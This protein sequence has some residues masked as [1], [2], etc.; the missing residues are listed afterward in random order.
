MSW[1]DAIFGWLTPIGAGRCPEARLLASDLELK[2]AIATV[3][4]SDPM[5]KD[6]EAGFASPTASEQIAAAVQLRKRLLESETVEQ[7]RRTVDRNQ[8]RFRI[9]A[10]PAAWE[11][12]QAT[13]PK[14]DSGSTATELRSEAGSLLDRLEL[15]YALGQQKDRTIQRIRRFGMIILVILLAALTGVGWAQDW[16][17]E[18][19]SLFNYLT[20][21]SAA[22]IGSL[23]SIMQ[24]TQGVAEA[25]PLEEDPVRQI[26]ALRHG[27]GGILVA[28][29]LGPM[30]GLT[31]FAV[32][33]GSMLSIAGLTPEFIPCNATCQK[34]LCGFVLLD[35]CYQFKTDIDAAKMMVW[36]FLAGFAERLVPDVLNRFADRARAEGTAANVAAKSR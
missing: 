6:I 29:L 34:D 20:V 3:L 4:A 35:Q 19:T 16:W 28:A 5:A 13:A 30:F 8:D 27:Y 36:A 18:L 14:F 2:A 26:S 9:A 7:L 15:I 1:L 25:A 32:F 12:Y 17:P 22:A 10:G 23:V 24:R 33:A 21:A 11:R 31:L